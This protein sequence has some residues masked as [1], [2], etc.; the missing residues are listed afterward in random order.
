[1][2]EITA[3]A[4]ISTEFAPLRGLLHLDSGET[5]IIDDAFASGFP[6]AMDLESVAVHE[7]MVE[8]GRRK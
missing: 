2:A 3:T 1:M 8:E 7:M 5:W 6:A 4:R